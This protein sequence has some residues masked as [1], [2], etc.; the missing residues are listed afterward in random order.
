MRIIIFTGKEACLRELANVFVDIYR[1]CHGAVREVVQVPCEE[2]NISEPFLSLGKR[3]FAETLLLLDHV[4]ESLFPIIPLA[5]TTYRPLIV[6]IS[7]ENAISMTSRFKSKSK[8][9]TNC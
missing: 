9:D 1:G 3:V 7:S 5:A 4:N 8:V 2:I 6:A